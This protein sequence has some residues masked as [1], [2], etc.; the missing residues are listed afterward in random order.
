[1]AAEPLPTT[2]LEDSIADWWRPLAVDLDGQ[3]VTRR[4]RDVETLRRALTLQL[5]VPAVAYAHGDAGAGREIIG[6]VRDAVRDVGARHEA[7][8]ED[9]EPK[10]LVA[11]A[12]A[13]QLAVDPSS[14]LSTLVSL[15]VMSASYSGLGPG[16]ARID[17]ADFAAR[18]LYHRTR[19]AATP[20]QPTPAADLVNRRLASVNGVGERRW[21][22]G[23]APP[24]DA[25]I[26]IGLAAR[27]D[28]FA[29]AVDR[30]L[31]A[32]GERV[33]QQH[34]A[35]ATWCATAHM[36][37]RDLEPAARPVVAAIELADRTG[38]VSPA[39]DAES[40]LGC[41][42]IGVGAAFDVDAGAAVAAAGPLIDGHMTD[43]PHD[44][45]FPLA[46]EL[47]SWRTRDDELTL[48][49]WG[50]DP[51]GDGEPQAAVS[52]AMQAYRE[53]LALRALGRG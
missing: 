52:I 23:A 10:A 49:G 44:G 34:W 45:L 9:A 38:G 15:L 3:I 19:R 40:L 2:L 46:T 12:L 31:A 16:I 1:M 28:E 33:A 53:A 30:G 14:D 25:D 47:E 18:Q 5:A 50:L 29:G 48:T 27:I 26:L 4:L 24:A 21:E 11:A 43:A 41:V 7:R 35:T 37:W 22:A 8:V 17:L 32:L 20:N 6:V 39:C 36:P 13:D 42:V 51:F